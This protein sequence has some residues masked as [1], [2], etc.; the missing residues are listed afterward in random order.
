MLRGPGRPTTVLVVEDETVV[1]DLL[2]QTLTSAGYEVLLANDGHQAM[3]AIGDPQ[4][5]IDV[6]ITDLWL[7]GV[8]GA[9]LARSTAATRPGARLIVSSGMPQPVNLPPGTRMLAKPFTTRELLAVLAST[10]SA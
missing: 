7:P 4:L 5:P 6:L 9:Q 10:V 3:A 8:D 1:R 2:L